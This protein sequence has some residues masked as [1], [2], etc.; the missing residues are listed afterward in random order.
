MGLGD[1][2]GFSPTLTLTSVTA[3]VNQV[4]VHFNDIIVLVGNALDRS[5][6]QIVSNTGQI[7]I[8]NA[9]SATG[10]TIHL[11]VIGMANGTSYTLTLPNLGVLSLSSGNLYAGPF[12]ASFLGV[13]TNPIIL[14][15]VVIDARTIEVVFDQPVNIYDATNENNYTITGGGGLTAS[16][17]KQIS[18]TIFRL[19]TSH[20][21]VGTNYT[22]TANNI[23]SLS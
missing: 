5:R 9:V 11:S 10:N 2:G 22:V 17:I 4:H 15:A 3:S 8:V 13:S 16:S 23:S 14:I 18:T 19:T 20:Q 21:M 12:L 6:Y 1:C 7:V